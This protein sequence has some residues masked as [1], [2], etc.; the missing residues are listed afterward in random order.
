MMQRVSSV[1]ATH[2]DALT[3]MAKL[4]GID[5]AK[6]INTEI[7]NAGGVLT[8]SLVKTTP[9]TRTP[10]DPTAGTNPTTTTYSFKGFSEERERRREGQVGTTV[11]S[12]V[13]ILGASLSVVPEVNDTATV[14]GVTYQLVELLSRDPASA[15]YEFR[16]EK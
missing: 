11:Y 14:D 9:G 10:S 1:T 6:V 8:G 2:T 3:D 7:A 15:V 5:I 12:V 16:A 4:F 13:T